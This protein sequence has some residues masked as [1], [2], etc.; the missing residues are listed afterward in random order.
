ML[1]SELAKKTGVHPET[2]RRLERRGLI[3]SRRDINNWRRY[4][5]DSLNVLRRLY[6]SDEDVAPKG[7]SGTTE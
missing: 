3:T 4:S 1:I 5:A 2:I 6:G 7:Q